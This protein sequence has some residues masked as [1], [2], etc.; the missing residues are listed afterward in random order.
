MSQIGK[1][2]YTAK[3]RTTGGRDSGAARSS[4]GRLDVRLSAPGSPRIGSNPEQLFAAGWS[5]CFESAIALAAHKRKI[6]LPADVAIDAEVDLNV[7]DGGYFL[8]AR[9]NV[10]VPGVEREAARALV[11]EA[12]RICPYS[13]ATRGNIEVEINLV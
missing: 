6:I 11:N 1:V 9:L 8:R 10:S 2:V 12:H 3:T 5:A 13:K 4:D 7:A